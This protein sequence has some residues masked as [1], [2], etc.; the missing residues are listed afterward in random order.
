[1][2]IQDADNHLY[3]SWDAIKD[4]QKWNLKKRYECPKPK[5]LKQIAIDEIS[6]GKGHRYFTI[7]LDLKS[8]IIVFVGDGKGSETRAQASKISMLIKFAKMLA[9][10]HICILSYY[11]YPI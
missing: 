7:V 8:W 9:S 3:V 10:H 5:K 11:N 1:M 4:I 2:T 6:I